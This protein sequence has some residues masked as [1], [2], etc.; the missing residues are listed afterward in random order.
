MQMPSRR[1]GPRALA[2]LGFLAII[3]L[4]CGVRGP[5]IEWSTDNLWMIAADEVFRGFA[6]RRP[7]PEY[8]PVSLTCSRTG[9]VVAEVMSTSDGRMDYVYILEAP[10]EEIGGAVKSALA[11]WEIQPP[12]NDDGRALRVRSKLY[13]YFVIENGEG[14]VRSPEEMLRSLPRGDAGI[15]LSDLVQEHGAGMGGRE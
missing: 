13:F 15:E 8:P 4:A 6:E 14:F 2:V 12:V 11:Q 7:R 3:V 10:N 5:E 9:V 1:C